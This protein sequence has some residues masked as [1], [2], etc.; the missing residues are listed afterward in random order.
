M[1]HATDWDFAFRAKD[2]LENYDD[3]AIDIPRVA[4]VLPEL[5]G[6]ACKGG[7]LKFT[8]IVETL[9]QMEDRVGLK[10]VTTM[11]QRIKVESG[12][13]EAWRLWKSLNVSLKDFFP[14]EGQTSAVSEYIQA[15]VRTTS[16]CF[17]HVCLGNCRHPHADRYPHGVDWCGGA[18]IRIF[19]AFRQVLDLH[20]ASSTRWQFDGLDASMDINQ[21]QPGCSRRCTAAAHTVG[22][23]IG[24]CDVQIPDSA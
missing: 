1:V 15:Q 9:V 13:E 19:G 14:A 17:Q 11:I 12:E 8:D 20:C 2:C 23:C 6:D 21:S 4:T 18:G 10:L 5:L 24:S 16:T 22:R 3:L 7:Y